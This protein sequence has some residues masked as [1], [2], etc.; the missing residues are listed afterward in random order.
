M[1]APSNISLYIPH[2]FPNFDEKYITECFSEFGDVKNVDFVAKIDKKGKN[3]N[4]VYIHFYRWHDTEDAHY[5]QEM[6][7]SEE[8]SAKYYH[9]DE[10][11]WIVLPNSTTKHV[12][13]DRKP[14]IDLGEKNVISTNNVQ[15]STEDPAEKEIEQLEEEINAELDEL[16]AAIEEEDQHLVCVDK[17][18]LQAM[19][20]ENQALRANLYHLEMALMHMNMM[21]QAEA[22]KVFELTEGQMEEEQIEVEDN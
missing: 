14:R 22:A 16:E 18:Y 12:S 4:S 9:D 2:V 5:F 20:A 7:L 3:Y 10:W 15:E 13:G 17:R 19:E 1:T 8:E 6:V 11:Y 21:Y